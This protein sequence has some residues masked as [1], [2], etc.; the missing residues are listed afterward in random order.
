[1]GQWDCLLMRKSEERVVGGRSVMTSMKGVGEISKNIHLGART[2]KTPTA[3]GSSSSS[4]KSS[5]KKG[6]KTFTK[7]DKAQLKL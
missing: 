6:C 7:C 4:T 3:G 1:M 2:Q 5:S